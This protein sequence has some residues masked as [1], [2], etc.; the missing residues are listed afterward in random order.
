[1]T[2]ERRKI[3]LIFSLLNISLIFSVLL[4]CVFFTPKD[5]VENGKTYT[6]IFQSLFNIYCPGCGGTRSIGYLLSFDLKKAFVFY[7]P[8]FIGIF[9]V[10]YFDIILFISF[11]KNTL[12]LLGR[13]K[14]FEFLLIPLSIILTFF[15]RNIF[16]HFG[17]DFLGDILKQ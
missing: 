11:K 13:F 16:L 17:I 5:I 10:F 9:L 6:C 1:M 15:I 14:Y 3:I 7:P 12:S 4:F 8:I 2:K